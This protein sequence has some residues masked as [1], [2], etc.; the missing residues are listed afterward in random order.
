MNTI[1][2]V[3]Y[4]PLGREVLDVD[5]AGAYTTALAAIG[6]PDWATSRYTKSLDDLAVVDEAMT[7][8]Q[9]KFRFPTETKFPCLPIR[10]KNQH[11]L[12]YPAG[13]RILVLRA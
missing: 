9:V 7:F 10:S 13:R 6:W 3:G 2:H 12:I 5:L 4:S 11:G 1:Y 8:A